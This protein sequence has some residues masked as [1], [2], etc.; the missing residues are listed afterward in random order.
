MPGVS[1]NET[2][3]CN[4]PLLQFFYQ[5]NGKLANVAE[6]SFSVQ[7]LT[8]NTEKVASTVVN[9]DLC[10]DGGLRLSTGRYAASFSTDSS[11]W[12]KGTHQ[13]TWSYKPTATDATVTWRQKF[14]VLDNVKFPTGRGYRNYANSK[15]LIDNSAFLGCEVSQIQEALRDASELIENYTGRL[16]DPTYIDARYNGTKSHAIPLGLPIIGIESVEL[17]SGNDVHAEIDLDS[18]VIYNRHLATGLTDPDDRANPR[19]EFVTSLST[20]GYPL[21]QSS[22]YYG[23][24]SIRIVGVFGYRDYDGSPAGIRPR[25]LARVASILA[26]R[27]IQD[28]FG[29]DVAVSQPGRIR[30]A[31][32]RDQAITFASGKDGGIGP[33]TGDRTVDDVLLAYMR[34][35]YFGAVPDVRPEAAQ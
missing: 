3:N 34:P 24:Q 14:E 20:E 32:T 15:D 30:S 11:T 22:F 35:P 21:L 8:D 9:L 16:F 1:L 31:R 33:L 12:N 25:R 27:Q 4:N 10:A 7:D 5:A 13:I 18:L 28:P 6:L 23:R 26:L 2:I 17:M 29:V 19:I